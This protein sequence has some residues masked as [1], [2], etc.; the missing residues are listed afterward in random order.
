MGR[1]R[2]F[3][4]VAVLMGGFSTEREIS[5]QSGQA[6]ARGLAEAG[7]DVAAVDLRDRDPRFP[8]GVEAVFIALHGAF[9]EDGGIQE[10]L[11]RRGMP[12]TGSGPEAS[13][14]AM[15]KRLSK[16]LFAAR[17]VPTPEYELL[18]DGQ[19]PALPL[20]V[21]VKPVAQ[22]SSIGVHIVREPAQLAAA[23][24]DAL[25]YGPEALVER[26]VAGRELTVGVVGDEALPVVEIVAPDGWY[27]FDAKYTRGASRY[28]V[29][30]PMDA[31]DCA[32]AQRIGLQ[33]FRAL[34]CRGLAR[35][36]CR[37]ADDGGIY[38][39]ELNSIPGFTETSLL[40]KAAAQ[41][42]IG[43]AELCARIMETAS[44]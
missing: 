2:R 7:Y 33:T 41:A 35:I 14:A 42:G 16:R 17:G 26:Y 31:A 27:G 30:A 18:R 40:P 34:G 39:L 19:T 20:P 12:Y 21:V 3:T 10:L 13:R 9:G 28:L 25:A 4:K 6:V 8:A 24:R 15:D 32:R 37:Y 5:L 23:L 36:D 11:A 29:P 22:G 38:V 1:R 43:F 44:L